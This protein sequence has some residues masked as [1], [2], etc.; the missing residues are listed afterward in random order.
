MRTLTY[1]VLSYHIYKRS[2]LT[3]EYYFVN[4]HMSQWCF[5]SFVGLVQDLRISATVL[6]SHRHIFIMNKYS[7]ILR[8][9]KMKE[10]ES[11][12]T[13]Q[14]G[15]ELCEHV[16]KWNELFWIHTKK[17]K[18]PMEKRDMGVIARHF[19]QKAILSF[20]SNWYLIFFY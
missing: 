13:G 3:H 4:D 7:V 14:F 6:F 8:T 10:R 1:S 11:R 5:S 9:Q 2:A 18:P 17:K 20:K 16:W 12:V 19:I 15:Y